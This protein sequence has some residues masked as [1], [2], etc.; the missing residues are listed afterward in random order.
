MD[1][2]GK[3]YAKPPLEAWSLLTAEG[4]D[5]GRMR[6]NISHAFSAKALEEQ[7]GIL[8]GYIDLLVKRLKERSG[9]VVDLV[10]WY[11][12]TTFDIIG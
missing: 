2:D 7:Q 10:N 12:F 11:N 1:K 9:Q 5:H 3:F 6:R 8:Q 4:E